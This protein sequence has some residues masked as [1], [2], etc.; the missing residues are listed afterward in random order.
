MNKQERKERAGAYTTMALV[1][2][3]VILTIWAAINK[4]TNLF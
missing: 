1:G 4:L 3:V 2:A